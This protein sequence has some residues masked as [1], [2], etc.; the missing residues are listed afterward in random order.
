M[1]I[2]K[3]QLEPRGWSLVDLIQLFQDDRKNLDQ[4]LRDADIKVSEQD[5]MLSFL[6]SQK[7]CM[8]TCFFFMIPE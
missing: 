2:W 3:K 1:Q 4:I 8:V 7:V 6:S 5:A